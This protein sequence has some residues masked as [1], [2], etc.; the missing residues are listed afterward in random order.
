MSTHKSKREPETI[1]EGEV[2]QHWDDNADVWTEH[3][4]KG[5]DTYREHLNNPAFLKLVGN[6]NDKKVLDAGCGEGYNTRIF[7]R[8]GAMMTGVDISPR[9]I[10]HARQAEK[11]SRWAS[12]MKWLL[13]PT[14]Q[15]LVMSPS[16]PWSPR[17]R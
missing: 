8:M 10:E 2:T 9:L 1:S 5:W 14:C 11:A 12:A 17:W 13:L 7:A 15:Y 3:V 6:L 4:R 16:I